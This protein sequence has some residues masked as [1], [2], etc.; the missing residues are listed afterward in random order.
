[1]KCSIYIPVYNERDA[2]RRTLRSLVP[3]KEGHEVFLV[4]RGSQDGSLDVA[5][6]YPWAQVLTRNEGLLGTCLNLAAAEGDG[7]VLLFLQPGSLM[8]RGWSAALAKHFSQPV[9][10]GYFHAVEDGDGGCS[11]KLRNRVA[12]LGLRVIGGPISLSGLAVRR[13]SFQKAHG[14]PPVPDHESL[15]FANRLREEGA[16]ITPIPHDLLLAPRA[17][18]R[19]ADAWEDLFDDLRSAWAFRKTES[20]DA[21]R[22]RRNSAA[23]VLIGHDFEGDDPVS[24]YFDYARDALLHTNLELVQSFRGAQKKVYLGGR[25]STASVGQPS[26]IK[27]DNHTRTDGDK[28]FAD[29]IRELEA[30][31]MD[32]LL[33]VR[34][35]VK[36]LS[37]KDLRE[38][39]EAPSE[40]PCRLRPDADGKE[41]LVLWID[42][43]TLQLLRDQGL[44]FDIALLQKR[45]WDAAKKL[46]VLEPLSRFRTEHDARAMYYAG[47]VDRLPA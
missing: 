42:T 31:G 9:D 20:F 44:R 35:T 26:G 5:K 22:C 18:S 36:N 38:L 12:A 7:D 28:R 21:T 29:L 39:A 1:M 13:D 40:Y 32:G 8:V 14:I 23:V 33:L 34:S 43:P 6:E 15:V 19:Q 17:G 47:L 41:W 4:D 3:E 25:K 16:S 24:D 11:A 46:D 2:L 27:V 30:D 10:A 45:F 37:H